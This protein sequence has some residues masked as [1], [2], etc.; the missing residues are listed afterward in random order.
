MLVILQFQRHSKVAEARDIESMQAEAKS[1]HSKNHACRSYLEGGENFK[2][3][4]KA[5][6]PLQISAK[7]KH[8]RNKV[9]KVWRKK[10]HFNH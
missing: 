3:R 2:G 9:K 1:P 7:D 10:I 6:S 4:A 5:I 8:S